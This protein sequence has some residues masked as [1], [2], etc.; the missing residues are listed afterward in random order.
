MPVSMI[1]SVLWRGYY[2]NTLSSRVVVIVAICVEVR[3]MSSSR[4]VEIACN[5]LWHCSWRVLQCV[6]V[7]VAVYVAVCVIRF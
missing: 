4:V 2:N 6:A 3:A 5:L 1:D 7:R